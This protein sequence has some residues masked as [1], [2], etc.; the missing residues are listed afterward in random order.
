MLEFVMNLHMPED[1]MVG[2]IPA[3]INAGETVTVYE[4]V[5]PIRFDSL[6]FVASVDGAAIEWNVGQSLDPG[7]LLV[8]TVTAEGVGVDLSTLDARED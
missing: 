3:T 4:G 5:G 1:A 7:G 2:P 6:S 8:L